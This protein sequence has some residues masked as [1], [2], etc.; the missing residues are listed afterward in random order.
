VTTVLDASALL[1]WLLDE[2]G[3]EAVRDALSSGVIAAPNWAEVLQQARY[4]NLDPG[5]IAAQLLGFGLE[6]ELVDREDAELAALLWDSS[7]PLSLADRFCIAVGRRLD[8][9]IWTCDRAWVGVDERVV[10]LR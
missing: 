6:V 4:R 7:A 8:S 9:P 5:L 2:P 10:V 1:A 3:G